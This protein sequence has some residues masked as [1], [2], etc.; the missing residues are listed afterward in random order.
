MVCEH[1]AP[2]EDEL[3]RANI[4]ETYRGKAWTKNCREW[5]YFD[6]VLDTASLAA[7]F[8]FPPCVRVHENLDPK[9]GV[10]RGFVCEKC[11]D[12]IMGLLSGAEILR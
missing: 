10:E 2:L 9:S 7:R 8:R 4:K 12:G 1:L 6:V 5:V 3:N 11:N